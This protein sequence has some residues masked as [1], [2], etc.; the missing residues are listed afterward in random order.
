MINT[1]G[2]FLPLVRVAPPGCSPFTRFAILTTLPS[3]TDPPRL[4]ESPVAEQDHKLSPG[5]SPQ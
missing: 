2:N 1:D 5:T 4:P 3:V